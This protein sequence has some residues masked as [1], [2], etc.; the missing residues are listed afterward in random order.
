MVDSSILKSQ[1]ADF[2]IDGWHI[3]NGVQET[4]LC[5][6]KNIF[7]FFVDFWILGGYGKSGMDSIITKTINL[8]PHYMLKIKFRLI[9]LDSWDDEI[10]SFSINGDL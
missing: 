5:E 2:N 1:T 3:A 4:S 9:L 6:C 8:P 7:H 10:I